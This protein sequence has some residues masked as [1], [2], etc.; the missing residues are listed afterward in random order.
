MTHLICFAKGHT[1][2]NG[3]AHGVGI[4]TARLGSAQLSKG[5]CDSDQMLGESNS[6]IFFCAELDSEF[7]TEQLLG[8]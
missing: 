7:H 6:D 3:S 2:K 4:Y 8:W 5:F 1:V